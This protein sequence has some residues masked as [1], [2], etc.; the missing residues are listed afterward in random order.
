M[1]HFASVITALI[2]NTRTHK[3][4]ASGSVGEPVIVRMCSRSEWA[5]STVLYG[6][7]AAVA[8]RRQARA[9]KLSLGFLL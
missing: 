5:Q 7:A 4:P 2:P 9:V 3:A 6:S 1:L 8:T